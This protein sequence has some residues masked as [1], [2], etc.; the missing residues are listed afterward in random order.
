MVM[1]RICGAGLLVER[2]SRLRQHSAQLIRE[3]SRLIESTFTDN[4][5]CSMGAREFVRHASTVLRRSAQVASVLAASRT[6]RVRGRYSRRESA[7]RGPYHAATSSKLEPCCLMGAVHAS[8][9]YVLPGY[10]DAS[11]VKHSILETAWLAT[12][13]S[14]RRKKIQRQPGES[15]SLRPS[16]QW[17]TLECGAKHFRWLL[18][19]RFNRA[20]VF[21]CVLTWLLFKSNSTSQKREEKA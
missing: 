15:S 14:L 11:S 13:S 20:C 4:L 2:L 7:N 5:A 19:T 12:Y 21:A 16:G 18:E 8:A 17:P 9:G 1:K 6:F 3:S 10:P